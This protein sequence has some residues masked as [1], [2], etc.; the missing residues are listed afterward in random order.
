MRKTFLNNGYSRA[1]VLLLVEE[2]CLPSFSEFF[3][4]FFNSNF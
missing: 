2:G 4:G 3:A 1:I